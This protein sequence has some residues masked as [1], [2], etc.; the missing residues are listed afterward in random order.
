MTPRPFHIL[1]LDIE[2]CF[3]VEC[4][5]GVVDFASW[6]RFPPRVVDST[7]RVLDLLE[8]FGAS[9]TCFIVGWVAERYPRIVS[10]IVARGHEPACHS[11]GHQL[12]YRQ[13]P[14]QFRADTRRARAIIE[15][16]AGRAI[17][18]Y[19]APS[20]SIVPSSAWA[21]D[22]LGEEGFAH[23]SSIFPIAHDIY[24]WLGA[25]RS[26]TV[27]HTRGG[28][29]REFPPSTFRFLGCLT[30]PVGGGGYL[31]LLPEWYTHAGLRASSRDGPLIVY[32][33]PW[34]L[35]SDQPRVRCPL[36]SR[37]RHYTNLSSMERRLRRVLALYPFRSIE[38]FMAL[39][40]HTR[41]AVTATGR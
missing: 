14:D 28:W 7:L 5:R 9:A 31:R 29:L 11:Y 30:L 33:H 2:E 19:R 40:E 26:I 8:E 4:M 38:A 25:E 13:T 41:S 32:F 1:T 21:L 35:D 34:E 10:E 16:A 17:S 20:F 36:R 27:I 37:L 23:D 22:I 12:V 18:S 6:E 39:A 24:G 3:Q 15:Q